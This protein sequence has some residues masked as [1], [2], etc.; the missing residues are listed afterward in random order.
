MVTGSPIHARRGWFAIPH[1]LFAALLVLGGCGDV[2][3]PLMLGP[4]EHNEVIIGPPGC[5]E[6]WEQ[7]RG[8]TDCRAISI[9]ER[10]ALKEQFFGAS[11]PFRISDQRCGA[12]ASTF[13]SM[14]DADSEA[15]TIYWANPVQTGGSSYE[16]ADHGI[17]IDGALFTDL[18]AGDPYATQRLNTVSHELAHRTFNLGD[19]GLEQPGRAQGPPYAKD[20]AAYCSGESEADPWD[21][22]ASTGGGSGSGT[23]EETNCTQVTVDHYWYYPDTGEIEYRY[24]EYFEYCYAA[25]E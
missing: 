15:N 1:L 8:I 16:H 11:S 13:V 24:T 14:L 19:Q 5:P 17:I 23:V 22:E 20:V 12:L 6:Y 2:A 18:D 25:Q 3:T 21:S 7:T 10:D 4:P 9:P